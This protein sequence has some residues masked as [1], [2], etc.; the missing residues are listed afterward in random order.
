MLTFNFLFLIV[1]EEYYYNKLVEEVVLVL[2]EIQ[3]P[4]SHMGDIIKVCLGVMVFIM[5]LWW[6]CFVTSVLLM[7]FLK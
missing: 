5:G 3:V 4:Q 6:M 1:V 7:C 2:T